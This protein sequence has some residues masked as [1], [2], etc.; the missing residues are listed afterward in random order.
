MFFL[1]A[2]FVFLFY[3]VE[4]DGL[5]ERDAAFFWWRDAVDHGGE[6]GHLHLDH[7]LPCTLEITTGRVVFGTYQ[8]LRGGYGG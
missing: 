1:F 5:G 8:G 3:L 6:D 4:R 7:L 2:F